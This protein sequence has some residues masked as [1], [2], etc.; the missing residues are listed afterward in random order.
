MCAGAHKA[1]RTVEAPR[2]NAMKRKAIGSSFR[3]I[4]LSLSVSFPFSEPASEPAHLMCA[5]NDSNLSTTR[6]HTT[7]NHI[8]VSG[9][10]TTPVS[11]TYI[12]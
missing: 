5:W 10:P 9:H 4:S 12:G 2:T 11:R 6:N 7:R 1:Q 3:S 8:S